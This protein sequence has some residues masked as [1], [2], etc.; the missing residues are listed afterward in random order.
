MGI[1]LGAIAKGYAVDR[2]AALLVAEGFS[3]CLV[4]GGGDVLGRGQKPSGPWIVG[5]RDPRGGP[6]DLLGEMP[7]RDAALVTSGDYERYAEVDGRRY[8]HILDP[9]SGRP[10]EGLA[11]VT[12][13][14]STAER[15]DAWATALLVMGPEEAQGHLGSSSGLEAL[16]VSPK[17]ALSMSRGFEEAYRPLG[18]AP[19]SSGD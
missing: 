15:A 19:S 6:G 8:A 9:R 16:L 5:V 4:N 11:S 1:G 12:V 13:L 2:V 18:P 14:A 7:L 10:A 17:G 3:S